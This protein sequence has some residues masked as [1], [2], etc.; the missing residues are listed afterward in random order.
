MA[1]SVLADQLALEGLEVHYIP[2]ESPEASPQSIQFH[3]TSW[4]ATTAHKPRSRHVLAKLRDIIEKS[5]PKLSAFL[6]SR[7]HEM[8][9]EGY[10]SALSVADADVYIQ[11]VAGPLTA[12]VANFCKRNTRPMIFRS[13]SLW[14]ADLT[15][16]WGWKTWRDSTKELYLQG[17]EQAD[18]VAPNSMDTAEAFVEHIEEHRIRFIPDG[19]HIPPCPDLRRE[20]G[21]VLWVGRDV[22]YKRAWL[23]ADLARMLPQHQFVMVGD[24]HSVKDVPANLRLLGPTRPDGL[25]QLYSSAKL[26][27]NTSEVEGFPNV[28]V[29]GAMYG[30]PYLSFLDP[31][32]VLKEYSIGIQ[33]R[34]PDDMATTIDMLM[35]TEDRRLALG[36]NARRFVEEHRDIEK[37][38][39]QWLGLFEELSMG[40]QLQTDAA[41][42]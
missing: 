33:P 26:L 22:A 19:F 18:I 5:S 36:R 17:I 3:Q 31:D 1:M 40:G 4:L 23:F 25:S 39:R 30:I 28:L 10:E 29:E 20:N 11:A 7:L 15:F 16:K 2:T 34:S 41:H 6:S 27:V 35:T 42:K 38:V 13:T 9:A 12:Y 14:D 32:G 37:V 24:I 21:F 8:L